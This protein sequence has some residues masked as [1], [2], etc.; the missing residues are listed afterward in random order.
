[1]L[2]FQ[3]QER[4][5]TNRTISFFQSPGYPAAT[6]QNITPTYAVEMN[7]RTCQVR[8]GEFF[9]QRKYVQMAGGEK[10]LSTSY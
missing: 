4:G 3:Y 10:F 2:Q 9:I 8:L 5:Q 1:V 7:P 6:T